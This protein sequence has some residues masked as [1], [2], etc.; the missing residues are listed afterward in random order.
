MIFFFSY[1][2]HKRKLVLW[3]ISSGVCPLQN[4]A[5]VRQ[6]GENRDRYMAFYFLLWHGSVLNVLFTEATIIFEW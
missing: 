4:R 3:C 5:T 1:L 6:V 2:S